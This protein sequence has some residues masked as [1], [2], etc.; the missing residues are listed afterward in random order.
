[1]QQTYKTC[2]NCGEEK[3]LGDFPNDSSKDDGH[4]GDCKICYNARV[5]NNRAQKKNDN[6][7]EKTTP[8]KHAEKDDD[9]KFLDQAFQICKKIRDGTLNESDHL[10]L[11]SFEQQAIKVAN[12][13]KYPP[14][15]V[16]RILDIFIPGQDIPN[17][18]SILKSK[19]NIFLAT[20]RQLPGII[21]TVV[22]DDHYNKT[23]ILVAI[24]PEEI[25]LTYEEIEKF[26]DDLYNKVE[27]EKKS[28]INIKNTD[29]Q[30]S[31]I[32]SGISHTVQKSLENCG[33]LVEMSSIYTREITLHEIEISWPERHGVPISNIKI[34]DRDVLEYIVSVL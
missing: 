23:S 32:S 19:L 31:A 11:K 21:A 16:L 28:K 12:K 30:I 29:L 1:M 17:K 13:R 26:T 24:L 9:E 8:K 3:S 5:R 22:K 20:N 7:K 14:T 6:F 10:F 2:S 34:I 4:R 25:K 27:P 33:E 15:N 18:T